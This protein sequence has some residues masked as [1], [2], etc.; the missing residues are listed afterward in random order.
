MQTAGIM[1]TAPTA[2]R[3]LPGASPSWLPLVPDVRRRALRSTLLQEAICALRTQLPAR[4]R[5]WH[6]Q[7]S[8]RGSETERPVREAHLDAWSSRRFRPL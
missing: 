4:H 1:Q 7:Q 3:A 6:A 2:R 5:A 8:V